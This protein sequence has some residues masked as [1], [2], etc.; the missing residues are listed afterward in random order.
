[1]IESPDA[2]RAVQRPLAEASH[3]PGFLYSSA[4]VFA[5]TRRA[6]CTLATTCACT[7]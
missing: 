5:A 4:E 1:M 2:L 3:A 6:R 7:A